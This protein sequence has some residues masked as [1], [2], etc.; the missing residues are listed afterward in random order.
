MTALL[1]LLLVFLTGWL[2]RLLWRNYHRATEDGVMRTY[3]ERRLML[4]KLLPPG[5]VF[6][7]CLMYLLLHLGDVL[8]WL[9]FLV[10][11]ALCIVSV[12]SVWSLASRIVAIKRRPAHK[13]APLVD[14]EV[15]Y[16]LPLILL[17]VA[18][19]SFGWISINQFGQVTGFW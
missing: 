1:T 8:Q 6:L 13:I 4:V 3:R 18:S 11:A 10:T 19:L 14:E 17:M 15:D 12:R 7:S 2:A 16:A 9:V 5:V